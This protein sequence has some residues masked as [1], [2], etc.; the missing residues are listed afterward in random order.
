MDYRIEQLRHQLRENPTSRHFYQLGELLRKEK[1]AE[2]AVKILQ[3]GLEHHPRYV[4][5]W[6]SL[7]RS[8]LD[9]LQLD[10][11]EEAFNKALG[12]DPE[13]AVAARM[14]GRV[15]LERGDWLAAVKKLKLA[16]ALS[17][18]DDTL[19]QEIAEAE[20]R[21][22]AAGSG[23]EVAPPEGLPPPEPE[24]LTQQVQEAPPLP[25]EELTLPVQ[26][27][28]PPPPEELAPPVPEEVPPQ[29]PEPMVEADMELPPPTL[30]EPPPLAEI[31]PTEPEATP[32]VDMELPTPAV[33]AIPS[34]PEQIVEAMELPPPAGEMPIEPE[35]MVEAGMELPPPT[36]EAT[37]PE[38]VEA[39]MELPPP[40]DEMPIEPEP[41]VEAGMELPP[42]TVEAIEPELV[43]AAMELPPPADEMPSGPESMV[44]AGME[45]PS[46]EDIVHLAEATHQVADAELIEYDIPATT[47]EEE[48]PIPEEQDVGES[49][50]EY[51]P[52]DD[53]PTVDLPDYSPAPSAEAEIET[54]V[55]AE[56]F[57]EPAIAA[58][59]LQ[60]DAEM[61]PPEVTED[62]TEEDE[63][64]IRATSPIEVPQQLLSNAVE[65][66]PESEMVS[67]ELN[68][69]QVEDLPVPTLTLARL[70]VEQSDFELADRTLVKILENEPN[71]LEAQQ[72]LEMVRIS[73]GEPITTVESDVELVEEGAA[74]ADTALAAVGTSIENRVRALQRWLNSI[75]LAAERRTT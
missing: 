14:I 66:L 38:L 37:E 50:E 63:E 15:A 48:L 13:N 71:N 64:D 4:S 34:S 59:E 32:T 5:A 72:L 56:D 28:P 22:A 26:Q 69:D 18:R 1:Q 68:G 45:L 51:S 2:E 21:L 29:A 57:A 54:P 11:A 30:E 42:P 47:S 16:R 3:A 53:A 49:E 52:W 12:F 25:P 17:P 58:E 46:Q 8:H 9:L 19:D 33:A 70:A 6:V 74:D 43:E 40:A 7:G 39:A 61:E 10:D 23:G 41:M 62:D 75:K 31:I 36:V 55:V 60:T 65:R 35:P 44:E 20:A 27:V 73:I 67:E 24:E